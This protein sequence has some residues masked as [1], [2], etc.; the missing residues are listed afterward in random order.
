[1]DHWVTNASPL[2][3]LAKAGYAGLLLKLPGEAVIP[4]AVVD[5]I[6]AGRA[7]YPGKEMGIDQFCCKS[8]ECFAS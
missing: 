3:C 4:Q 8:H 2:I 5:E 1:M 7:G 6:Q